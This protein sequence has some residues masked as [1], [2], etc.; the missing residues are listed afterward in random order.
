MPR[1]IY[2]LVISL[3]VCLGCS[4]KKTEY[5]FDV[6]PDTTVDASIAAVKLIEQLKAR[7]DTAHVTVVIPKGRYD[8]YPDTAFSREYYISNHDQSN[9]RKVGFA[10]E[11]LQNVTID[12]QGSEFIFHG[13]MIP[14]AILKGQNITLKNFSIDFEIPALRQL[15]IVEVDPDKDELLAEIYPGGNY[16]IDDGKLVLL[17]EGFEVIPKSSMAFRPD[18]HLTY[19]RQD[20]SF[21][22]ESVTEASPDHLCIRGWDQVKLTSPGE[23]YVLRSWERPAPGIFIGE[24]SNTVIENV[25]VHYAEGMG[26]LAQM[27]ENIT[28]DRFSVCLKENDSLR[29][30][31]TQADA[32]HFSACKGVILSRNGLY[33][34]MADDAINVHGTYLRVTKRIND[35]TIQ[36]RYMHPQAWGFK[37]GETGDSVQFVE[38][39]KMERVEGPINTI[40][41]IKAID[42]TTEFGAKEFEITFAEPLPQEISETGRYGIE[43]LTWTPEVIFSDNIIRNNRARGALFS[44]PHRV[45]CENN[46]FDHTHGTAILLCGDCNGWYET[47]ACKEVIIRNNRFINGLTA[48]YQFT[49]AIISIYPE[50]PNLKDQQRFFHSGILI[51]K[52]IFETFDRPLVYAKSTDGLTIRNNSVT[53]NTDFEPFHWNKHPFFF[54]RVRNALIENNHFESGWDAERDIRTELSSKD[55]VSVK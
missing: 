11:N 19:N 52:N 1:K 47:G 12:G 29:Y 25:Q 3:I 39:E 20:I 40:I 33:E 18:K 5:T 35:N 41:S 9:P 17:G 43:N 46:L 2:L 49:N 51:E 26:L 4:T 16:R 38:S 27:S 37:W 44:T 50:I 22:P 8:F 36:A 30:F 53:Y 6:K 15:N 10:L 21:N 32:T 28:L 34:M 55:A 23:R 48:Y 54:E 24:S 31:T 14:F 42:K 45:I 13:R 7:K